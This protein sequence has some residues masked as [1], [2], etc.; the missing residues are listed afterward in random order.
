MSNL[1]YPAGAGWIRQSL[2]IEPSPL[3][4]LVADMLGVV[5]V[6]I[7]NAPIN[8]RK[9]DWC[10]PQWIEVTVR[11][12]L[13]TYDGNRLTK[14]VLLAHACCVR[15]EVQPRNM[16]CLALQFHGRARDGGMVRQHPPIDQAVAEFRKY[17]AWTELIAD[18]GVPA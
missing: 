15:V 1:L 8:H 7:Y 3:G 12:G 10:E 13:A 18:P 4:A 17:Y 14:L 9:V 6:G 11:G 5:Y 16:Q 2:K